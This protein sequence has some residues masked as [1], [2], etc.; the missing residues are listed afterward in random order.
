MSIAELQ[1]CFKDE[2]FSHEKEVRVILRIPK[3]KDISNGLP[4]KYRTGNGYIIPY[5]EASV[6]KEAITSVTVGPLLEKELAE[7]NVKE[8]MES[9]GCSCK[10]HTSEVPIRF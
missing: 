5:V 1:F 4:T 8:M 6:P 10:V 3:D 9:R 7:K 2:H